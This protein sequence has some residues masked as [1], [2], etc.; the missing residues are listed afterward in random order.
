MVQNTYMRASLMSEKVYV[1]P[2]IS[3]AHHVKEQLPGMSE[4][5]FIVEPGRRGTANCIVAALAHVAKRHD[6]DE[7]VVFLSADHHIRDTSGFVRSFQLAAE[8]SRQ[9]NGITLIGIEPNQPATGF[10]YIERDSEIESMPNVHRVKSFTEKPDFPT[11]KKY[12]ASGNYLWNCG[13]FVGSVSTFLRE[14]EESAPELKKNYEKLLA[15]EDV[16]SEEYKETYLSFKNEVIDV[17]LI[18]KAKNLTVISAN[19]DWLDL[20]SFNDLHTANESNEKGNHLRGEKIYAQEVENAYI[21]NEEDKPVIVIGLDNVA[22]VNTPSGILVAR[23]DLSQKVGD[24]VKKMNALQE[25][26]K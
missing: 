12:I 8:T 17:A 21:R 26:N 19:F 24:I 4:D 1:V 20:G 11:A 10:G 9:N 14:M 16:K 22:I 25:G 3:H 15:I 5:R 7:P 23:K 6:H 13:Y 18:E 2:D